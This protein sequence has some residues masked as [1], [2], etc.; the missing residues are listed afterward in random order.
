MAERVRARI[1]VTGRVQGVSFRA[2]AIEEADRLGV[3]GF[4]RNLPD[5]AVEVEAEGERQL[6]ETM[7]GWCYQGPRWAR[8]EEVVVEWLAPT[9][10]SGAFRLLW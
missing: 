5:G 2:S 10:E 7:V 8:V 6:V 3:S 4:V 9:G 1:R